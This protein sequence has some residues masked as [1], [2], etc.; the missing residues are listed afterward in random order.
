LYLYFQNLKL[1]I[2]IKTVDFVNF[3]HV[4]VK[5]YDLKNIF[6]ILLYCWVRIR[7]IFLKKIHN[8]IQYN[9]YSKSQ[10]ISNLIT[11]RLNKKGSD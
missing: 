7:R 2:Y 10:S 5:F 9:N 8:S 6:D 11:S 4:F 3:R 1:K